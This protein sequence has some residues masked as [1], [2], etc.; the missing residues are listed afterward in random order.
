M[1]V[2]SRKDQWCDEGMSP[3]KDKRM[4]MTQENFYRIID[5]HDELIHEQRRVITSLT[6]KVNRLEQKLA[7][8]KGKRR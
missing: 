6:S 1:S 3:P 2:M 5:M 8:T 4:E 7:S